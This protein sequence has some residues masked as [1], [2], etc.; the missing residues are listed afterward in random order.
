MAGHLSL[1]VAKTVME[2]GDVAW[3][4]VE[5]CHHDSTPLPLSTEERRDFDAEALPSDNERLR[6]LL[7]K[8]LNLLHQISCSPALLHNCPSDL[9]DCI[10]SAISSENFLDELK[11]H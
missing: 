4:A 11:R 2:V 3:A 5:C 6:L 8:N 7:E 10:M 1:E 9:H